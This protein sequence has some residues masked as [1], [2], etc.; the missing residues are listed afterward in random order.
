MRRSKDHS[1]Q[2]NSVRPSRSHECVRGLSGVQ[3]V[4]AQAKDQEEEEEKEE[5]AGNDQDK[6][7]EDQEASA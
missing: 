2:E 4:E 5:E 7:N 6:E 3:V 1:R